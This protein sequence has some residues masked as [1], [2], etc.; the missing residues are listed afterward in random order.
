MPERINIEP[1]IDQT[2]SSN[3]DRITFE[4]RMY[5][6]D[7]GVSLDLTADGQTPIQGLRLTANFPVV[8]YSHLISGGFILITDDDEL[9]DYQKFGQRQRLLYYTQAELD[10]LNVQ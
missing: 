1:L 8:P 10:A 4:I 2:F 5:S 6:I 9:P 7:D 3:L